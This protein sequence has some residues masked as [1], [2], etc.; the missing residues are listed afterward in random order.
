MQTLEKRSSE[1]VRFDIDCSTLL[2]AGETITGVTSVA[3]TPATT[4]PLAFG[5]AVINAAPQTY[6]DQYGSTRTAAIGKVVQV[7]ISGGSI[8]AGALVQE[9]IIRAL[10]V[11][12]INTAVEAT[13][14]LR[15]N[16]TPAP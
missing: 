3:A 2:A 8:A 5:A 6:T 12:S 15:L 13:V 11:T 16:D 10:L 1:A 14:R 9:Y 7:Q 4:T